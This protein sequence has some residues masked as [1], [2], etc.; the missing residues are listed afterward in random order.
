MVKSRTEGG[1]GMETAPWPVEADATLLVTL[2][3]LDTEELGS[4]KRKFVHNSN[5][6]ENNNKRLLQ[7]CISVRPQ[8]R[9]FVTL[10]LV[11]PVGREA[12]PAESLRVRNFYKRSL[13]SYWFNWWGKERCWEHGGDAVQGENPTAE[14]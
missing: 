13:L 7:L 4:V 1:P 8:Q 5:R 2:R 6:G 12:K 11:R 10:Y 9:V 14:M 3:V